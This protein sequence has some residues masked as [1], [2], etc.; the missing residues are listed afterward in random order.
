MNMESVPTREREKVRAEYLSRLAQQNEEVLSKYLDSERL[1]RLKKRTADA[2]E[3]HAIHDSLEEQIFSSSGYDN[4]CDVMRNY[5]PR[6]RE[7]TNQHIQSFLEDKK[8]IVDRVTQT[9][10]TPVLVRPEA[11]HLSYKIAAF[12][13]ERGF[14][15]V[16]MT[17]R[18][19]SFEEYWAIYEHTFGDPVKE[20]HVR[21]RIFGYI[22][23]PA[24]L[25][26][27][28]N[29]L[30][31]N[32]KECADMIAKKY[33]GKAGFKNDDTLRGGL[34]YDEISEIRDANDSSAL[35]A[36]DPLMEYVY[37]DHTTYEK[38]IASIFHA[39]LPGVHIPESQEVE[40]DLCVLL[41]RK[42]METFREVAQRG[43]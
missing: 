10:V 42:E 8:D 30:A 26:V 32:S 28:K 38:G 31:G 17:T 37:N 16:S 35:F 6:F 40:K 9:G 20:N 13:K 43:V 39:N 5:K 19:V 21:R 1:E 24:C 15:V 34:I 2:V 14:E 23:R 29:K 36:L 25:L 33:K 27:V 18:R 11:F 4:L 41:S 22:N 12:L 3:C 7:L